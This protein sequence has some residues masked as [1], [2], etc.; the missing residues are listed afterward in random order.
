VALGVMV[1]RKTEPNRK[2]PF[3]TPM[4]WVVGPLAMAGCLLLFFSLGWHPTIEFF[5]VWAVIG[6][7]IYFLFARRNSALAPGNV[8]LEAEKL[9]A[10]P[11]FHEGPD[12]GP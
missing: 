11:I 6:L 7:A 12:P 5:C 4:V 8:E 9:E 2:R 1:L 3:R 10:A